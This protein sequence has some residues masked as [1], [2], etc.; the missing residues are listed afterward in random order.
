MVGITVGSRV[1]SLRDYDFMGRSILILGVQTILSSLL[2]LC[3]YTKAE[4][5]ADNGRRLREYPADDTEAQKLRY[6]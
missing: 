2:L 3:L 6:S 4:E 1:W 5:K